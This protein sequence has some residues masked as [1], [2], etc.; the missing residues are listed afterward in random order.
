M[1]KMMQQVGTLVQQA[2][3]LVQQVGTSVQQAGT[4]VQYIIELY[5]NTRNI[6]PFSCCY[7]T[8]MNR[9]PTL[10]QTAD[11]LTLWTL[12]Q[13]VSTHADCGQPHRM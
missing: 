8:D 3:T 7:V 12:I 11:T 6:Y 10:I 9:L 5:L 1:N 4:L 2:G 13:T